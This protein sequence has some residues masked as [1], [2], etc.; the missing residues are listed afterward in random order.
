MDPEKIGIEKLSFIFKGINSMSMAE[1][2]PKKIICNGS[3]LFMTKP[4]NAH[5]K[6]P[7]NEPKIDLFQTL[8]NGKAL[9]TIAATASP[10]DRNINAS[11]A[12]S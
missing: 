6:N 7:D 9:P 3:V 4:I 2:A 12:I 10:T 8:P 11:T 1:I 5:D